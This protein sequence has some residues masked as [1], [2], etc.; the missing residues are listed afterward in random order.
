VNGGKYAFIGAAC[1]VG[2]GLLVILTLLR[3]HHVAAIH[4]TA[5]EPAVAEG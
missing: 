3:K 5:P 2:G 1:L 4:A